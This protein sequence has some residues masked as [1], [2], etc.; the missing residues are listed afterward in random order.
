MGQELD[1]AHYDGV[2]K[3][4]G[5]RGIYHLPHR[6]SPYHALWMVGVEHVKALR[7][8]R[9]IDLGCGSGHFAELLAGAAE[10]DFSY[11]GYD[12]S[13]VAVEIATRRLSADARFRFEVQDL[14]SDLALEPAMYVSFEFMEHIESD[15]GV[16]SRL[17]P[18]SQVCL[19]VPSYDSAG[20]VRHFDSGE[21]A[22][23]RYGS[24]IEVGEI[25]EVG[26]PKMFVV[27]GR[28]GG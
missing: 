4:G 24:L 1:A 6:Q 3:R 22:N 28:R 17:P 7:P 12:F 23:A 10:F 16:L 20:H 25:R 9:V 18:G 5:H 26:S 13:P 11:V 27:F 19:S 15:L 21:A 2:W 14:T 8:Q